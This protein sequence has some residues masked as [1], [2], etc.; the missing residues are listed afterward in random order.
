MGAFLFS[1]VY[2]RLGC[3]LFLS[4]D[5]RTERPADG[6][7]WQGLLDK[8]RWPS[9]PPVART[10]YNLTSIIITQAFTNGPRNKRSTIGLLGIGS[11]KTSW[12]LLHCNICILEWTSKWSNDI[13]YSKMA[14]GAHWSVPSMVMPVVTIWAITAYICMDTHDD[15]GDE[16]KA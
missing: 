7:P 4:S 16:V 5:T 1:G 6:R 12:L 15:E 10:N 2:C 8:S 13:A 14:N 9:R 3:V 11:Q